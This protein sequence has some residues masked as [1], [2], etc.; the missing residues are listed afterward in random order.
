VPA[1]FRKKLVALR[2]R[3]VGD[4]A[5]FVSRAIF[6]RADEGEIAALLERIERAHAGVTVGSYPRFD[7]ADHSVKVTF[8]GR[9][10]GRVLEALEACLGELPAESVVRVER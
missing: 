4:E 7:D 3:L 10:V 8:D 2:E 5:A 6:L 9:D 1:I